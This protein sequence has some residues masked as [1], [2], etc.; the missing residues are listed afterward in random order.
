MKQK[1]IEKRRKKKEEQFKREG[2]SKYEKKRS[3]LVEEDKNGQK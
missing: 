3:K 2:M 1:T